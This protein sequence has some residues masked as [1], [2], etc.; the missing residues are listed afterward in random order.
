VNSATAAVSNATAAAANQTAAAVNASAAAANAAVGGAVANASA[1]TPP[2][3][4]P[5]VAP[6]NTEAAAS[7]NATNATGGILPIP[8]TNTTSGENNTTPAANNTVPIVPAPVPVPAAPVNSTV[9][10]QN[11]LND[12]NKT[13]ADYW[14][15][16]NSTSNQNNN[17]QQGNNQQGN[18]QQAN[19][20]GLNNTEAAGILQGQTLSNPA[21]ASG[22]TQQ[23]I[24]AVNSAQLNGSYSGGNNFAN[25]PNGPMFLTDLGS[26]CSRYN[27]YNNPQPVNQGA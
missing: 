11:V 19:G 5:V 8:A 7:N 24:A 15:W 16:S 27:Y 25:Q 21:N 2:A 6:V 20:G 3:A 12:L 18:N 22:T 17:N 9:L 1:N 10:Q 23:I 4:V 14:A 13:C 26:I